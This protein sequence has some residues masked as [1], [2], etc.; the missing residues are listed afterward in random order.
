[1][2][3]Q[4][5][6]RHLLQKGYMLAARNWRCRLGEIDLVMRDGEEIV[7]VEVRTR[8]SDSFGSP[9]ES[10][11]Y[12][13]QRKLRQL[14]AAYLRAHGLENEAHRIDLVSVRIVG[15]TVDVRQLSYV[16]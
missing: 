3:E 4:A 13:K 12:A 10:V 15:D 1:M 8:R 9:E 14:A 16:C 2:G 6:L 5:A 11:D 7:F